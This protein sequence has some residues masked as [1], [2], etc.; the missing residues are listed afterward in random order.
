MEY[1][2]KL[3]WHT[4]DVHVHTIYN[5]IFLLFM[6]YHMHIS[7][8]R[9]VPLMTIYNNL[10]TDSL[11]AARQMF[12]AIT[13]V[14]YKSFPSTSLRAV[15]P[16]MKQKD[17]SILCRSCVATS[18]MQSTKY[19]YTKTSYPLILQNKILLFIYI[20]L[21]IKLHSLWTNTELISASLSASLSATG[22]VKQT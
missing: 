19:T 12:L 8:Y 4:I 15:L 16:N 1:V 14:Y 6:F 13:W 2:L 22:S 21:L 3:Q 18:Q 10:Q 17:S 9:A 11:L 20:H 7:C 5:Y